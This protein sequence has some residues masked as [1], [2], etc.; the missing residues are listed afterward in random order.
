M[1]PRLRVPVLREGKP[2]GVHLARGMPAPL[3]LGR[4]CSRYAPLR[5]ARAARGDPRGARAAAARSRR[6][7]LDDAEL[8]RLA[9]RARP[10]AE[11]RSTALWN[12]IA[13]PTLNLPADE[14]SLGAAVKVFRTGLLDAADAADIGVSTVPLQRLH[15]DAAT[16]ALEARGRADRCSARRDAI[17]R[18]RG[19]A[20]AALDDGADEVDAVVV[21]VPHSAAAE[22]AP[23]GRRRRGDGGARREPDREPARPLRPPRARRAVRG[24]A[25]LAGAVASSTAPP[26]PASREGQLVAVSLSDA[27]AE[28]GEPVAALRERYLPAL[29]RLLPAARGRGGARLHRHARAAR[30]VPRRARHA[31]AAAGHAHAACRASTSPARGRTPAGRRR[32]RAPCERPRRGATRRSPTSPSGGSARRSSREA[33]PRDASPSVAAAGAARPRRSSAAATHLLSLQHPDGWWKGELETN[34]TIDAEDLFLRRYLGI[35]DAARDRGDRALDPLEAARRRHVGDVLRR[36]RPTSRRRSRRTSR[37]GSPATPAGRRRTCAAP[38]RSSATPAASRRTRVFTRMWLSLLGALVVGRGAGDPARADAAAAARAALDLL[39]RLLGAAD[40]RRALDLRRALRPATPVPFAIDELL[41]GVAPAAPPADA[42][43]RTFGA[44]RPRRCTATSGGRSR[45]LRRRALRAAERW[46]VDRQERDG[47]WG[48][49]QPPWVWSI[50]ALHALGYPLDHPVLELA[51]A[52]L[53]SFTI[54]DDDG[55]RLEACQSPVWDTALAAIALLDAGLPRDARGGRARG[56]RGSPAR[57]V[58]VRGDWAVRRPEPRRRAASRSSSRTT[59]TP[60]STTPPSSC[61]RCAARPATGFDGAVRARARV[62][63]RDAEP[64]RRLGRVRRRQHERA[65]RAAAVLRLRRGHRPAER[66][67][68]RAHGRAARARGARAT[69]R[70]RATGSTTCCASRSRDGSW[71]GRWG[72]NHVYGIGAVV[73][74]ARRVRARAST[75]SVRAR[76]R[77]ARAG[78]ER[79]RRLRRGPALVPR[80]RRGAAAARRPRRRPRGRCSPSTPPA[81]DGDAV[82]RAVRWLVETQ[83]PDGRL[84]RAVLHGH[85]LP[86]RLLPELPPVPAGL[87]GDGARAGSSEAAAMTQ[88]CS[89]SCRCAS[90][91]S[92]SLR[93]ARAGA[94]CAPGWGRSA[95]ASPRRAGSRS[96]RDAV[97]IA[98]V[99]ARGLARA[100]GRATSCCATE[101]RRDGRRPGRGRPAAPSVAIRARR[102]LRAHVGPIFSTDRI[103][104]PDERR[105]LDGERRAR[106]RHGVGVARRRRG[107]PAAR[108]P[109]RRRRRRPDRRLVDPRTP[110]AGIRAL[111]NLRRACAALAEWARRARAPHPRAADVRAGDA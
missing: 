88:R 33:R 71:F 66:R 45:P 15:G 89:C 87:S 16:A 72:A 30:D 23:R 39:V 108:R 65:R 12:L 106:G 76:D 21:A 96:R 62:G 84:G 5:A 81:T 43:S 54:E 7:A 50:V 25:R 38:P 47:S 95:R 80:A 111:A 98:G 2:A 110:A 1:Q 56:A 73:P 69:R 77:V 59:T 48:G 83:R 20:R 74:G 19:G 51:L 24:R 32:W 99:C 63:A 44:A 41:T 14:A 17:E 35:L 92:R 70:P 97:A 91:Q 100:R 101:L 34:V 22:L 28:I 36:A 79:R 64:R 94:C 86:G 55:R 49:I 31:P 10:V 4:R 58:L 37:S 60:T 6:P 104:S 102:G 40:D 26:R 3:H 78:A 90:R 46:I 103:A 85:R 13:L 75:T 8:R 52:G 105:A 107:R 61:S 68:D 42:W 109:A 82:E 29:E 11:P 53:D 27:D 57:E 9:A 67:R 93:A 18:E